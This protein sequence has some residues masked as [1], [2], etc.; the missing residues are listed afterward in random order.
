M[1]VI[2]LVC[3]G[4]ALGQSNP[5]CDLTLSGGV[6]LFGGATVLMPDAAPPGLIGHWSFDDNAG[7]DSSG[8]QHHASSSVPSGPAAGGQGA[9]AQFSGSNFVEIPDAADLDSRIFTLTTWLFLYRNAEVEGG[10]S[11]GF[12]WCPILQKGLDDPTNRVFARAPAL[13][14]D[15]R[16]RGLRAYVSTTASDTFQ[17]GEFVESNARIPYQRWTHL[18]IVRGE[19]RIRLYVNGII[20]SLNTTEGFTSTNTGSLYIGNTPGNTETC[21][22]AHLQDEVRLYSRELTEEEIEAEASGALG[23]IE[24]RYVRLGC[25]NCVLEDAMNACPAGYHLC[26]SIELHSGGYQ[27]ARANGWVNWNSRVWS[28]GAQPQDGTTEGLGICCQDL[29]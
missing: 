8:L 10:V 9:S 16:D 6:C 20:D 12:R 26:T 23:E 17:Q 24:P 27:V 5:F 25:I 13:F 1:L 18:A 3:I 7:L 4:A 22:V 19:R 2:A 29:R 28:R 11:T 15:R 14:V 21:Q